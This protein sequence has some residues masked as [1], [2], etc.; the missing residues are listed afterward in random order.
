MISKIAWRNV[1]R[2]PA[3]SLVVIGAIVLGVWALVFTIGFV[4]SWVIKFVENSVSQEYSNFQIHEVEFKKDS[5]MKFFIPEGDKLLVSLQEHEGVIAVTLR[6]PPGE[7]FME[8]NRQMK[9]K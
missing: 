2:S 9:R 3:R 4:N 7:S 8:L 6:P 1:W 5:E